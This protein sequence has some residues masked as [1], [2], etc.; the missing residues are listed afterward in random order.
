MACDDG[1]LKQ[2]V[3]SC[4]IVVSCN[5]RRVVIDTWSSIAGNLDISIIEIQNLMSIEIVL[6]KHILLGVPGIE[7]SLDLQR[8]VNAE[9]SQGSI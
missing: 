8:I 7:G 4:P 3:W 5:T 6:L 2:Y 1:S 9:V